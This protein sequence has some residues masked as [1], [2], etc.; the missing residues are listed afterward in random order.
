MASGM[1]NFMGQPSDYGA[2][3]AE[4]E[5][6]RAMAA[7][8]Q[9]QS[10]Q[11]IPTQ[12]GVAIHPFQG[13]AKM[14]QAYAGR[15]Q[16]QKAQELAKQL[17]GG[18]QQRRGADMSL[19]VQ[20]LQGRPE[21]PA[22]LSE[23]ASGNVSETPAVPAQAPGQNMGQILPMI[24]DPGMQQMGLQ[25]FMAQQPQRPKPAEPFTLAPGATRYGPDGKPIATA[26]VKPDTPQPFTLP[27]GAI[28]YGPDGKPI[29]TAPMKPDS[30]LVN[31]NTGGE[32][33][34]MKVVGKQSGERDITQHDTAQAALD[35]LGKLDMVINHLQNSQA[36]TGMGSEVFKTI[37]QA[38]ALV[39]RSEQSG[40][41][42]SDT[43]L[44]DSLLGSDVFPQIK[45]LGIGARG[46]DTPAEREFLRNVMT[47]TTPLN[48]DT[49]V[50]MTKLRRDVS[51]RAIEKWNERVEKGELDRYFRATG[52]PKEKIPLPKAAP[53]PAAQFKEG[54]TA[55][56]ANGQK[57]IFRG[58][59]WVPNSQ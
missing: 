3:I 10:M 14:A 44:L 48:K 16:S 25:A 45:A 1:P 54:Q 35:N 41:R 22:G 46:L 38:K 40:K 55:T 8:L 20:A 57:I 26:P 7:A 50:R 34:Y 27:P 19:L 17:Q 37:E 33:E 56:G 59:A 42:V 29:A 9:N 28:R 18:A 2:D 47:G 24:Q 53:A 4:I 12:Q 11:D 49:L 5:R 13:L 43:E 23:D 51:I 58:G 39:L 36:I 21:Q 30:P 32:S 52:L 15:M 6:R 31:V